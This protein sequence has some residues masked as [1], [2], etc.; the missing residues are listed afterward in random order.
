MIAGASKLRLTGVEQSLLYLVAANVGLHCD[1]GGK[2]YQFVATAP[3][4]LRASPPDG[5]VSG[6]VSRPT[7]MRVFAMPKYTST[8]LGNPMSTRWSTPVG[9]STP[10]A[11][12]TGG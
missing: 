3:D 6:K 11:P 10:A 2:G 1:R 9:K 12:G 7:P 8:R 5:T 4:A